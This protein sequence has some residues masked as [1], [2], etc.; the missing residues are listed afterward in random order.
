MNTL[1][2]R[3]SLLDVSPQQLANVG[4]VELQAFDTALADLAARLKTARDHLHEVLEE[5][6]LASAYKAL[7]ATGRDFGITHL[8][9]GA[10]EVTVEIPKRVTWDQTQLRALAERIR[11]AGD[12]PTDYLD[13]DLSVPEGRFNNWPPALREQFAPSR[14]VRPGKTV[15]RLTVMAT[16]SE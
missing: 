6:Y 7:H 4:A 10:L 14:T 8:A 15:F 16:Q 1:A 2:S 12:N 3:L 13:I 5:R 11:A 9:D